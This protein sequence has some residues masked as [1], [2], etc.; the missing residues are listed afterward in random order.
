MELAVRPQ[1]APLPATSR[2]DPVPGSQSGA[3]FATAVDTTLAD[4]RGAATQNDAPS[5]VAGGRAPLSSPVFG[6]DILIAGPDEG[7]AVPPEI[8][9]ASAGP[10]PTRPQMKGPAPVLAPGTG[11]APPVQDQPLVHEGQSQSAGQAA[12][13]N[14]PKPENKVSEDEASPPPSAAVCLVVLS[15]PFDR[16]GPARNAQPAERKTDAGKAEK[17]D[18]PA[19]MDQAVASVPLPVI[20]VPVHPVHRPAARAGEDVEQDPATG[21]GAVTGPAGHP[22]QGTEPGPTPGTRASLDGDGAGFALPTP[23]SGKGEASAVAPSMIG[24][25]S[26]RATAHAAEAKPPPA[27][28]P[29]VAAQPGRLGHDLGVEIARRISIGGDQ[30]VV[31]LT[32]AEFGRIEVRMSFDDRGGLSTVF[33]ADRPAALDMLRRD[34]ADLSRA[35]NDAGF[36]SDTNSLRFDGGDRGTGGQSRTPWQNAA[37][38][39]S[40]GNDPE[41]EI[42]DPTA[43]RAVQTR[44]RYNLMA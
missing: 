3:G 33:A 34:S 30:L 19:A 8:P 35:L 16:S 38:R 43:F 27:S 39:H 7:L 6:P 18:E 23:A 5:P 14:A 20:A 32:P 41:P 17:D 22:A 37:P 28:Q 31:R 21:Q 12:L 25:E 24:A 1:P 9:P 40:H 4:S 15:R 29:V 42:V 2:P 26:V 36:R 44:G 11:E 13:P 10:A